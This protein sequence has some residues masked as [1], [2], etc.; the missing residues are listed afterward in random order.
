MRLLITVLFLVSFGSVSIAD[1]GDVYYCVME[2]EVLIKDHQLEDISLRN[3]RSSGKVKKIKFGQ[4]NK[5]FKG[6]VLEL[7]KSQPYF[8]RFT[9]VERETVIKFE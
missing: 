8:E 2:Q 3:F 9:I 5:T 1:V 4:N 6:V 7:T